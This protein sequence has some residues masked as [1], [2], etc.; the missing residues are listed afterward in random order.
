MSGESDVERDLPA[1]ERKIEKAREDG[2]IPRS[3]DFAGALVVLA[4]ML[5][6]WMFSGFFADSQKAWLTRALT[7]S[8]QDMKDPGRMMTM[9]ADLLLDGLL[10]LTPFFLVVIVCAVFGTISV[11]GYIFATKNLEPKLSKMNPVKGFKNMFSGNAMFEF[12]KAM[13]KVLVIGTVASLLIWQGMDEYPR[14]M[15]IPLPQAIEEAVDATLFFAVILCLIFAVAV[16]GDVPYQIYKHLKQLRMN[17]EEVKREQKESDGDPQI[18]AKIRQLQREMSRSRMMAAVP[19]ADVIVTNPTHYA[20]A[21]SYKD[22]QITPVVVAKGVEEVAKKIRELGAENEVP[23]VEVPPLARALY[24]HVD[25]DEEIPPN[26][27]NAVAKVLAY[28]YALEQGVYEEVALP[29]GEDIPEG[30]DP[31]PA[32]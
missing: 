1:T 23:Q 7:L 8:E 11:G 17:I 25:I 12:A 2:Q 30:M 10:I 32:N 27:Y 13:G 9:F 22:N 29:D 15:T 21:L 6:F 24:K 16:V 3:K 20:V 5:C 28:L 26:L 14:M 31:G 18:K 19:G 4:G